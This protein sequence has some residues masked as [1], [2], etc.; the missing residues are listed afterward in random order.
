[1]RCMLS[2]VVVVT[3]DAAVAM[4]VDHDARQVWSEVM[5]VL[6]PETDA[7]FLA[8]ADEAVA[9]RLTSPIATTYIDTDKISFER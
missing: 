6:P 1:M 7:S 3:E 8:P 4:E 5:R 2:E 9:A